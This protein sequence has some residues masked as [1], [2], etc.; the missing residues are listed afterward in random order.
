MPNKI[1][2]QEVL[3]TVL[4]KI[5]HTVNACPITKISTDSKD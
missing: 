3:I 2:R 4:A 5:E 1:P